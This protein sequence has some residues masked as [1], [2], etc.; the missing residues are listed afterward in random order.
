MAGVILASSVLAGC[1]LVKAV[2][3]A[4][5]TAHSNSAVINLFAANLKSGQPTSFEVTYVTTGSA[6][7]KIIYAVRPPN[8]LGFTDA[9]TDAGTGGGTDAGT[10]GAAVNFR[11]IVNA[12]GDYACTPRTGGGSSWTCKKLPKTAAAAQKNLLDFYT[13]AHWVAFLR[14]FALAAGFAGDKISSSTT[15]VNGFAM[16]C[17]DFAASGVVGKSTICTTTT[18]LLGYVNV[19]SESTGFEITSYTSSPASSLFDLPAGAKVTT[20]KTGGQ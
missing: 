4:E 3:K 14:D 7:S 13:P 15:T 20:T 8:Q 10:G 18:H 9:G 12:S 1:G 17:V 5:A 2:K 16:Q 19:A 6:P 11:F